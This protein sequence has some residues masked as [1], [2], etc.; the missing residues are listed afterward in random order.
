MAWRIKELKEHIS[1]RF[2]QRSAEIVELVDSIDRYTLLFRYHSMTARDALDDFVDK[3]EPAGRRNMELVLGS[4]EDYGE[5]AYA[6][7]VQEA[8]LIGAIS[9]VRS[10]LDVFAQLVNELVLSGSIQVQD[11][12]VNRVRERLSPGQLKTALDSL[13]DS[14]EYRYISGF[15]NTVK[16]RRLVRHAFYILF[17]ENRA[18]VSV[19]E[20]TF[21]KQSFPRRWGIDALQDAHAVSNHLI[22]CGKALNLEC[23]VAANV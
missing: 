13:L 23:G 12:T 1:R 21:Q 7:I 2:P 15:T 20:F 11:C 14:S 4:S 5:Y 22:G 9:T 6:K 8:N 3:N 19:G 16:H 18:E 10:S 17:E